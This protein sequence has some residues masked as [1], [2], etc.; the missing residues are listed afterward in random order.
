[1]SIFLSF[2]QQSTSK[3]YFVNDNNS[4]GDVYTFN[5]G[6]DAN[7]GL[8]PQSP[9]RTLKATYEI[10]NKGDIIYL[11][12]GVYTDVDSNGKLTFENTKNISIVMAQISNTAV[13][14]TPLPTVDKSTPEDF[15]I[16]NDK[17]VS[18]EDYLK[19]MQQKSKKQ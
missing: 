12:T 1:L 14:K 13:A 15:Y 3:K 16:I 17:P 11:D 5:L 7:D 18:R 4:K 19:Q 8:S 10:A 2:G 6:N 9:K